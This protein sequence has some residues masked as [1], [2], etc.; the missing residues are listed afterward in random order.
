MYVYVYVSQ[1]KI[2]CLCAHV[3]MSVYSIT[4]EGFSFEKAISAKL[5]F[6]HVH[7]GF[8]EVPMEK[9]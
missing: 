7:T 9:I 5:I 4:V 3:Y 8:A 6:F 2:A 1:K